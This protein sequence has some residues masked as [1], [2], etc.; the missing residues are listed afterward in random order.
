MFRPV[1][2]KQ[3]PTMFYIVKYRNHFVG[4]IVYVEHEQDICRYYPPK[5]GWKVL[6]YKETKNVAA[7]N[8]M[9][10]AEYVELRNRGGNPRMIWQ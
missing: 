8:N 3:Q 6:R 10:Y 1:A 7:Y 5:M 4:K 9:K 2:P